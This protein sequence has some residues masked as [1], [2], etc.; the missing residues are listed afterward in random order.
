MTK[1]QQRFAPDSLERRK[2]ARHTRFVSTGTV[3]T[4]LDGV[5]LHLSSSERE[6]LFSVPNEEG[7]EFRR[8]RRFGLLLSRYGLVDKNRFIKRKGVSHEHATTAERIVAT[9]AYKTVFGGDPTI[10]VANVQPL[11][12]ML[13]S[14]TPSPSII[15]ACLA[16]S[17]TS[18]GLAILDGIKNKELAEYVRQAMD[19]VALYSQN[20]TERIMYHMNREGRR[21]TRMAFDC[22]DAI[23]T[24][25][26]GNT[27][28]ITEV[29]GRSA[30]DRQ[31][32]ESSSGRYGKDKLQRRSEAQMHGTRR[33]VGDK[34]L[35]HIVPSIDGWAEAILEKM[36]LVLPHTGRKGRK[37]IPMPYGKSIRFIVREDTDPEQRVFARKT[38]SQGGIVIVDCSGSMGF[39]SSDLDKIMDATAGASVLCYS[40]GNEP[41][42]G[43]IWLVARGG[44][45]TSIMPNFPGN[46]GV[47][48][49][50]LEYGLSLRR[51]NEPVVWV[52]DTRVTGRGDH[53]SE[54]LRDWCLDFCAKHNI[55]I[56]R[57]TEQAATTLRKLQ[58]GQRPEKTNYKAI[59]GRE[60][61]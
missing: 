49:P 41:D 54:P 6:H 38:R 2:G 3:P 58:L 19:R 45:R 42:G 52:S 32:A 27:E 56:V 34:H 9:N 23:I 31:P 17:G 35:R 13:N 16:Y 21:H 5:Q 7:P 10:G 59:R 51:H 61:L 53:A 46:N 43:N 55:H 57:H 40:S 50:A 36:P 25:V 22:Y 18:A 4:T 44:R 26:Q 24:L 47:D 1:P 29:I 30:P 15:S 11:V 28:N 12:N 39:D 8:L 33:K 14:P 20:Y 48:G 37:L 60:Y